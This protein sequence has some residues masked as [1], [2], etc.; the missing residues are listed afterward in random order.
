MQNAVENGLISKGETD[1]FHPPHD[2]LWGPN[3]KSNVFPLREKQEVQ[4]VQEVGRSIARLEA[5][6]V[7]RP[8]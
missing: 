3:R 4:E 2:V 7:S 6:C 5:L 1:E 8:R